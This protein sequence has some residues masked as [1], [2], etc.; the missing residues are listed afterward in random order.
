MP[1]YLLDTNILSDVI[2]N[3]T[4]TI[5]GKIGRMT[6][7]ERRNLCTSIIVAGELR[8]GGEKKNSPRLME[9]I[10]AVLTTIHVLPLEEDADRHYGRLRAQLQ[11]AGTPISGN[12]LLIAAHALVTNSILVTADIREFGRIPELR[13][14]NW[15][16]P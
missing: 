15:L 4:G 1:Q 9:R 7:S 5:V 8:F 3:R 6:R 10:D 13:T 11:K 14:E 2:R 16:R 12:D